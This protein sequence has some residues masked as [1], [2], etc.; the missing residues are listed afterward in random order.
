MVLV[1]FIICW[2]PVHTYH[3]IIF[4]SKPKKIPKGYCNNSTT[5]FILYWLSISSCCYNPI[6]YYIFDDRF[7]SAFQNIF[8]T[9]MQRMGKRTSSVTLSDMA[10]SHIAESS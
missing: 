4:F 10:P 8:R 3:L 9:T 6:I 5:Y 2:L 1:V 7:R